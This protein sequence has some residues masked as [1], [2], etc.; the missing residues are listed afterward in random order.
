[1]AAPTQTDAGGLA[2]EL[3]PRLN[4]VARLLRREASLGLTPQ[5]TAVLHTLC[6]G[7][8][9]RMSELADCERVSQPTMSVLVDRLAKHG[10][11]TR[12]TDASDRRAVQVRITPDGTAMAERVAQARIALLAERLA[13]LSEAERAAIAAAL[14]A[15]DR[16]V[17]P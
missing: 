13:V 3:R 9:R 2:A 5:Q 16:L 17:G 12:E 15:L 6:D 10:W 1:M 4:R 11:V 7:H 8:P 14:P